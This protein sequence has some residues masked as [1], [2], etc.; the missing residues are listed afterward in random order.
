M[1]SQ[2]EE[3]RYDKKYGAPESWLWSDEAVDILINHAWRGHEECQDAIFEA[4]AH[5]ILEALELRQNCN[6]SLEIVYNLMISEIKN[7]IMQMHPEDFPGVFEE[8][9]KKQ[10]D[11]D[12]EY[13]REDKV[14]TEA[15]EDIEGFCQELLATRS[16]EHNEKS[17]NK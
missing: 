2:P 13:G 15:L 16:V 8:I 14:L 3:D 12:A 4:S 7:K 10:Y 1:L 11:L 5:A 17:D 9:A 6:S